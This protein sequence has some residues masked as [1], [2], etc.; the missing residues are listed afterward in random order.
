MI[1]APEVVEGDGMQCAHMMWAMWE[2]D[3]DGDDAHIGFWRTSD[4]RIV[5]Q[6]M[7]SNADVRGRDMLKWIGG[8]GLP[9]HV[10]EVVPEAAGFWERMADERAIKDLE[11]ATGWPSR[12]ERLAVPLGDAGHVAH[13]VTAP[14]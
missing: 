1:R 12:L 11:Y 14:V 9:V 7:Q 8:Y 13:D 4:D 2:E 6:A 10:V 5:I 3:D